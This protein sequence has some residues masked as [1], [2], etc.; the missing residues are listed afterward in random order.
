MVSSETVETIDGL[1][2]WRLCQP[3]SAVL[4][5]HLY[6]QRCVGW[7]SLP[8]DMR[9]VPQTMLRPDIPMDDDLDRSYNLKEI[10]ASLEELEAEQLKLLAYIANNEQRIALLEATLRQ[11][12]SLPG[13]QPQFSLI[14]NLR[15]A[16]GTID[17]SIV[18]ARAV[19][20][21]ERLADAQASAAGYLASRGIP[22]DTLSPDAADGRAKSTDV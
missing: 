5:Q 15:M 8:G 4:K 14:E 13:Y 16:L 2:S 10:A 21:A 9:K 19:L 3:Y 12:Q 11:P 18:M 1:R 7:D 22:F 6:Q 17:D 20:A